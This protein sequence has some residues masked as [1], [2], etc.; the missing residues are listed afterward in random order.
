MS[1]PANPTGPN[2]PAGASR[3]LATRRSA[4]A[5]TAPLQI[6]GGPMRRDVE[7]PSASSAGTTGGRAA[8]AG[9]GRDRQHRHSL[10]RG[11]MPPISPASTRP[12]VSWPGQTDVS[13]RT[14]GG[15]L[16]RS[17]KADPRDVEQNATSKLGSEAPHPRRS[18]RGPP[19]QTPP[20]S[21]DCAPEDA[22]TPKAARQ[23]I[24]QQSRQASSS[25]TG[26]SLVAPSAPRMTGASPPPPP[27]GAEK[28]QA[29]VASRAPT[30]HAPL[31][32][33][34]SSNEDLVQA[35]ATSPFPARQAAPPG[36]APENTPAAWMASQLVET[37]LPITPAS[38]G[39][40]SPDTGGRLGPPRVPRPPKPGQGRAT[41]RPERK[42][43]NQDPGPRTKKVGAG[44][45]WSST[46]DDATPDPPPLSPAAP[47][48][49]D[50]ADKSD[51]VL[52]ISRRTSSTAGDETPRS[53]PAL[54]R[55]SS[56]G[57][58]A[59]A[60]ESQDSADGQ[61]ATGEQE[62]SQRTAGHEPTAAGAAPPREK[63]PL[64]GVQLRGALS[65]LADRF[66]AGVSTYRRDAQSIQF[67]RSP[68]STRGSGP[69][70]VRLAPNWRAPLCFPTTSHAELLDATLGGDVGTA[71]LQFGFW[72]G[73]RATNA[74]VSC[75]AR[76]EMALVLGALDTLNEPSEPGIFR[77]VGNFV[78]VVGSLV[79]CALLT[80]MGCLQ[81]VRVAIGVCLGGAVRLVHQA[82]LLLLLPRDVLD[83]LQTD[84]PHVLLR[85]SSEMYARRLE[86]NTYAQLTELARL[87][88]GR[89]EATGEL[90]V[91]QMKLE[92]PAIQRILAELRRY[93]ELMAAAQEDT[94]QLRRYLLAGHSA[95]MEALNL[96]PNAMPL[97]LAGG[98]R[99]ADDL[100]HERSFRPLPQLCRRAQHDPHRVA[101]A[102]RDALE[103]YRT[104][105][106]R[107]HPVLCAALGLPDPDSFEEQ[108]SVRERMAVLV[109][110]D[111]LRLL[112]ATCNDMRNETDTAEDLQE[113][114]PNALRRY[115]D[116]Q[117]SAPRRLT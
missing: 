69:K 93:R 37:P 41:S 71:L 91:A 98:V 85:T 65:I 79:G 105:I 74:V 31:V 10:A 90:S 28:S 27:L 61:T 82:I 53:R 11:A 36:H 33:V 89:D 64:S 62:G 54:S 51:A 66:D 56:T 57:A 96:G 42:D 116:D 26:S 18:R 99:S 106:F 78:A 103:H 48:S 97:P 87:G 52:S 12:E 4:Q 15:A 80:V 114:L 60:G 104:Q 3:A 49:A 16:E 23:A 30:K 108:P 43:G 81:L 5:P 45:H 88:L 83:G 29:S 13:D 117:V 24:S 22:T 86:E 76:Q 38:T 14:H 110:L 17:H 95:R 35:G 102:E 84:L 9:D 7:H 1:S 77:P 34:A 94:D 109:E 92:G 50:V 73:A 39:E 2:T 70:Q 20:R 100:W 107:R 111:P 44:A 101:A 32:R 55:S 112:H 113:G 63:T 59:S 19:P 25:S 40:D 8:H 46:N 6:S 58:S 72:R 68:A 75:M 67:V 47:T 115:V 21:L